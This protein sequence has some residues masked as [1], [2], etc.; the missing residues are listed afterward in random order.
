MKDEFDDQQNPISNEQV[1]GSNETNV[2]MKETNNN[3]TKSKKLKSTKNN[4][5]LNDSNSIDEEEFQDCKSSF[6]KFH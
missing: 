6:Q 1:I 2:R 3:M 4:H 5:K